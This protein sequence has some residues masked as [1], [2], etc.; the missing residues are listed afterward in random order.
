M[1]TLMASAVKV[2]GTVIRSQFTKM[3]VSTSVGMVVTSLTGSL[4]QKHIIGTPEVVS[5]S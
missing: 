2:G 5:E 4:Y 1:Q 3:I